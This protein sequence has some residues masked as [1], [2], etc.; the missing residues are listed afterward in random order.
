MAQAR[1]PRRPSIFI[2]CPFDSEF[3]PFLRAILFT[4]CAMGCEPRSALE[5]S[6]SSALRLEKIYKLIKR[7]RLS[8]HDL[9]RT[10]L[11]AGTGLPRFNMPLELGILLGIKHAASKAARKKTC[12]IFVK[13]KHNTAFITD[14]NG[15]DVE[16]HGDQ[17]E[18]VIFSIRNWL[19]TDA[20]IAGLPGSIVRKHFKRFE[21]DLPEILK[22]IGYEPD[23]PQYGDILKIVGSWLEEHP[24]Q[25]PTSL[26]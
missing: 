21:V 8:I 10:E 22:R 20:K 5:E 17:P 7:C 13:D 24:V 11:S 16:G 1:V 2:N 15:M 19:C 23:E 3:L 25:I 26:S 12:L 14:I 6:D 9:S 4:V 18:K